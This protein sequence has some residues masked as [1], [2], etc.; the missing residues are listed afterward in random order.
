[1]QCSEGSKTGNCRKEMRW[2][3]NV[4][5]L[6]KFPEFCSFWLTLKNSYQCHYIFVFRHHAWQHAFA[7][8]FTQQGMQLKKRDTHWLQNYI[9]NY[10]SKYRFQKADNIFPFMLIGKCRKWYCYIRIKCIIFHHWTCL[11]HYDSKWDCFLHSLS[12]FPC[13]KKHKTKKGM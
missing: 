7:I 3:S 11:K 12:C 4:V 5:W 10:I 8:P 13:L 6:F 9:S 1:M 2:S